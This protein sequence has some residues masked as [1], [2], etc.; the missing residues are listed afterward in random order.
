MRRITSTYR[1][2]YL[3]IFFF[4]FQE[5]AN[6]KEGSSSEVD[7]LKAQLAST[8]EVLEAD[9]KNKEEVLL[10]VNCVCLEQ[11]GWAHLEMAGIKNGSAEVAI[12]FVFIFATGPFPENPTM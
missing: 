8:K 1:E 5:L 7:E 10:S 6:L 9:I 2:L 12:H 3:S 11:N 4:F